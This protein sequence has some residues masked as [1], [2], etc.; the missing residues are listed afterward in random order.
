M[1]TGND[2]STVVST[3][4]S[5]KA[6]EYR[7]T[8][9]P[10]GPG[11]YQMRYRGSRTTSNFTAQIDGTSPRPHDHDVWPRCSTSSAAL[12]MFE[13]S[14]ART[15][16]KRRAAD[17]YCGFSRTSD[18]AVAIWPG[19]ARGFSRTP[20]LSRSTRTVLSF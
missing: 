9:R 16:A 15:A 7:V 11:A 10:S 12:G 5:N 2:E 14:D 19:V 3:P 18:T 20:A 4:R 13:P 1:T 8:Q 6:D 17:A